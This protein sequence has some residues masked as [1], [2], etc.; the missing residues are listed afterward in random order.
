MATA[1]TADAMLAALA[2]WGIEPKFYKPDWRT[3]NRNAAQGFGPLEGFVVH[4]FGSDASDPNSL[5]YLY[6]GD[7]A[8]GMPG[9]L[10]QFAITDDGAVWIIGWGSANHTGSMARA[11]RALVLKDAAPLAADFKPGVRSGDAGSVSGVNDNYLG[12]EMTYGKA[13]TAAQRASVVRLAAAL[14]DALGYT[15]GSVIGHR[16]CT[17]DR[18][19]P[20]GMSMWQ[21]R[22]DVNALLKAGPDRAADTASKPTPAPT[23]GGLSMADINTLT[24]QL[25]ALTAAV[26]GLRSEESGRYVVGTNRHAWLAGALNDIAGKVGVDVDES[27]LADSI[28]TGLAPTVRQAVIDAGQ[29]EAVADAVVAKLGAALTPPA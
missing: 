2:K 14:M 20:V 26:K 17:V 23:T 27:A 28:L 7:T 13:P 5:A 29:P 9:P 22:R 8:R 18:S 19:D 11:L 25:D 12:V 16:E 6:R 24:A 10:S 4:N 15:G 1:L 3:H 21:L